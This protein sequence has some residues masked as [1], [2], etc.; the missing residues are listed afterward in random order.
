M[1]CTWPSLLAKFNT[2]TSWFCTLIA[3]E[4]YMFEGKMSTTCNICYKLTSISNYF[5]SGITVQ[6]GWKGQC[7]LCIYVNNQWF[8]TIN[9]DDQEVLINAGNTNESGKY[10]TNDLPYTIQWMTFKW[11]FQ[12]FNTMFRSWTLPYDFIFITFPHQ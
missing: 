3:E 1:C 12:S 4:Y 2:Y 10:F 5:I 11:N 7:Y 8:E 6:C 9:N